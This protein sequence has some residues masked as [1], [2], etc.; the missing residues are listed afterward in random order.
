MNRRSLALAAGVG[1]AA[2]GNRALGRAGGTLP[3]ALAGDQEQYRWRGMDIAYA[4]M[5]D[6]DDP[7]VVLLHDVGVVGTSREFVGVAEALAETH[8]V[9]APDLP[10]YGRS[11]RPPLTYSAS[12]YEAFVTDFVDDVPADGDRPAV[13]ASG[14]TGAYAALAARDLDV[15]RLALVTPSGETVGRSTGRRALLRS[16]VLGTG[17]YN[18]LT[19]TAGLRSSTIGDRCFGVPPADFVDY[20][21]KTAHQP[22]A[23]F[24]PASYLSGSLDPAMD[25]ETALA[26][27]ET[28]VTLLWGREATDPPLQ[29]GR[30]LAEATDARLV[31]VD[32]AKRLPHLEH[33]SETLAALE[34]GLVPADA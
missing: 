19:S 33:P 23:K 25:V 22:G 8:R 11:D 4:A 14:L 1:I 26:D 17:I 7:P 5:G 9:Y 21:W 34:S 20:S 16:P 2:I 3:P 32:Y 30:A 29:R 13:V 24:A 27:V 15:D 12:I 6:P 10:G 31:V 18:A 28:D